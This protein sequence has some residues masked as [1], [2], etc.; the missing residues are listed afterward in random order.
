MSA[1]VK[2]TQSGSTVET[3]AEAADTHTNGASGAN[4]AQNLD[5]AAPTTP[6]AIYVTGITVGFTGTAPA[7]PVIVTLEA[8][9]GTVRARYVFPA[10]VGGREIQ[11]ARPLKMPDA[12]LTRLAV[13]A[14]GTGAI[15]NASLHT[16]VR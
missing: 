7:A 16:F 2:P 10:A 1:P 14:G 11:F 12:T 6:T 3:P 4:A 5:V 9:A 13:P 15:S 8:P